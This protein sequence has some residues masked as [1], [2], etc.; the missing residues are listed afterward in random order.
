MTWETLSGDGSVYSYSIV[1]RPQDRS[2]MDQVPIVLAVISLVEGVQIVST[3]LGETRQNVTIGD[4][5]RAVF[6]KLNNSIALP[7]FQLVKS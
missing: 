2:F 4:P 3:V 5:V 1:W 7:K 6:H